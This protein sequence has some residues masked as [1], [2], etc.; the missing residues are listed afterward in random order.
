MWF[1]W[2]GSTCNQAHIFLLMLSASHEEQSLPW[3]ILVLFYIWAHKISSWKYPII[4]RPVPPAFSRARFSLVAQACPTLCNPR[5]CIPC[6]IS[7]LHPELLFRP[8]WKS[9]AAAEHKLILVE[10]DGKCPWW[11]PM[12]SWPCGEKNGFQ[13]LVIYLFHPMVINFDF[14]KNTMG[15]CYMDRGMD[16]SV[17]LL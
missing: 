2:R 8:C 12:C 1:W 13:L 7:A 11:V 3:G 16:Y 5:D 6:L 15:N 14:A 10:V 17:A 4:W 9:A